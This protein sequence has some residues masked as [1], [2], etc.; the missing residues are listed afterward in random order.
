MAARNSETH[1]AIMKALRKCA[2]GPLGAISDNEEC[3][4]YK[5]DGPVNDWYLINE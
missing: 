4:Q 3:L 1:V 5:D 2:A